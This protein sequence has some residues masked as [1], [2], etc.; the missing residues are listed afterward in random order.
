MELGALIGIIISIIIAFNI[1]WVV[2]AWAL[3]KD[4]EKEE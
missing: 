3:A 4:E 1:A 2:T